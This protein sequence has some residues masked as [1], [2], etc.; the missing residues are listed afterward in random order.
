MHIPLTRTVLAVYAHNVFTR[1]KN[2]CHCIRGCS[3]E[4]LFCSAQK[5][6]ASSLATPMLKLHSYAILRIVTKGSVNVEAKK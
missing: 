1:Y 4:V 5:N 3:F 2:T 6:G